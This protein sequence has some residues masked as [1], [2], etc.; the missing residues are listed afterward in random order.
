M[1]FFSVSVI[2]EVETFYCVV[3]MIP[4]PEEVKIKL[5]ELDQQLHLLSRQLYGKK[6]V[7]E[8]QNNGYFLNFSLE[9]H[10]N[11]SFTLHFQKK[12]LGSIEYKTFDATSTDQFGILSELDILLAIIKNQLQRVSA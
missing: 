12:I 5:V 1:R 6:I 9:L 4:I 11:G 2:S 3:S 10:L 7:G 8:Y